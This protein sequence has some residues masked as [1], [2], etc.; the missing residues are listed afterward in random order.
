MSRRIIETGKNRSVERVDELMYDEKSAAMISIAVANF[1]VVFFIIVLIEIMI[2]KGQPQMLD[3]LI[4]AYWKFQVSL[5]VS[6]ESL[7]FL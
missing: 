3:L 5:I 4:M 6:R 7:Y 1:E 2:V